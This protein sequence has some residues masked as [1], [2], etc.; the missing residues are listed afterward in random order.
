MNSI[1][2]GVTSFICISAGTLLGF[3][4][5]PKLPKDHLDAISRDAIK[6]AWGIL[7]T[8]VAL[9]LGLL[10]ASA[11][12]SFDTIN[13]EVTQAGAKLIVLDHILTRYGPEAKAAH[14]ELRQSVASLVQNVWSQG[15]TAASSSTALEN[16]DGIEHV[17]DQ[18]NLLVPRTDSQRTLLAQAQQISTDLLLTRWLVVEQSQGSLPRSFFV[19]L[20][21]WL[22]I[23]FAGIGLF[24]PV[25]RTLLV[26][27]FL[28]NFSFSSAIFL[29]NEVNQPLGGIAKVSS[30]P[31]RM[32]LEQISRER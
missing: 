2:M 3:F 28:C 25:N 4:I 27:L 14:N 18:L 21:S 1:W 7:A 11:K 23:L 26:T 29:I 24:A 30:I 31:I 9:V 5:C 17:Q 20:V 22:S 8:M 15:D 10:L 13:S 19:I 16:A 12:S 6:M 32:A